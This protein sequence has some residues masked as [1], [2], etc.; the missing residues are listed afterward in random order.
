MVLKPCCCCMADGICI[1]Y[2]SM[3]YFIFSNHFQHPGRFIN[4]ELAGEDTGHGAG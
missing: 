1:G 4:S 3:I 2:K